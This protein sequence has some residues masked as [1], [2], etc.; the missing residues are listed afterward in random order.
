MVNQR[1][2]TQRVGGARPASWA[3]RHASG[4]RKTDPRAGGLHRLPQQR[5]AIGGMRGPTAKMKFASARSEQPDID[6]AS[7]YF[8]GG[9]RRHGGSVAC[10]ARIRPGAR[11][12][13]RTRSLVTALNAHARPT[14]AQRLGRRQPLP[15]WLDG[16][17]E[18]LCI[19]SVSALDLS[20][21]RHPAATHSR[22]SLPGTTRLLNAPMRTF[23]ERRG[24]P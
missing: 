10:R 23:T 15:E 21:L 19:W 4:A 18:A 24:T 17:S 12:A 6:S 2:V 16:V 9:P 5:A 3:S 7:W 1:G 22:P 13:A 14:A 20:P 8:W 11:A